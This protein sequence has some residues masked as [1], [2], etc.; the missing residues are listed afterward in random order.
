MET[1]SLEER[2]FQRKGLATALLGNMAHAFAIGVSVPQLSLALEALYADIKVL[3][4]RKA[5][6]EQQEKKAA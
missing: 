3:Q 1:P 6:A 5:E 2:I 4:K